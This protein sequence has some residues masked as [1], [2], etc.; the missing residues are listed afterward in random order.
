[1]GARFLT[2]SHEK[3]SVNT[4]RKVT[5]KNSKMVNVLKYFLQVVMQLSLPLM[6][7]L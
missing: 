3:L 4:H 1:M 6:E 2:V 7:M 5:E